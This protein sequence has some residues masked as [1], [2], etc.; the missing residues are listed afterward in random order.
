MDYNRKAGQNIKLQIPIQP[1]IGLDGDVRDAVI[2]ILNRTLA[3]E[4]ILSVKTRNAHWNGSG[5]GFIEL[6]KVYQSQY[7]NLNDIADLLAERAR[8]LGGTAIGSLQELIDFSSMEEQPGIT[9]DILRLLADHET[10]IRYLRDAAKKCAQDYEDE[11]T[12]SLLVRLIV[13][14]EMMAWILRSNIDT[15]N[16]RDNLHRGVETQRTDRKQFDGY[17]DKQSNPSNQL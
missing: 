15:E 11:G 14:H 16:G 6:R 17:S 4:M 5:I 10:T 7:Q 13:Q 1:N 9:P 3:N 8:M 12:A 2:E